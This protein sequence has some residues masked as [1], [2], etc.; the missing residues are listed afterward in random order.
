MQFPKNVAEQID[1]LVTLA[2]PSDLRAAFQTLTEQYHQRQQS[3][4]VIT[5]VQRLAYLATRM[6]ATFAVCRAVLAK[7]KNHPFGINTLLD[8]GAGPGTASLAALENFPALSSFTLV[9]RDPA[10][11]TYAMAFLQNYTISAEYITKALETFTPSQ[12]YDVVLCSYAC[13][14]LPP[15]IVHQIID[16]AWQATAQFFVLIEPGTPSGF[17]LVKAARERLLK[18]DAHIVA[19]CTHHAVCPM[20][21]KDWCHFV[22]RVERS[23]MHRLI[24]DATLP[25]EDEKYTYL[26]V[27]RHPVI[28]PTSRIIKRPIQASGHMIFDLCGDTGVKRETVSKR[29]KKQYALARHKR[30]GDEWDEQQ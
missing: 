18:A 13:N 14:E 15:E 30:W 12:K 7:L 6:P 24:K 1:Q 10:L 29:Q 17:S 25:Y 8:L 5:F 2:A 4:Y 23:P 22:E 28:R 19:P 16:R 20:A 11:L 9:D 21:G 26:I 27:S 3:S